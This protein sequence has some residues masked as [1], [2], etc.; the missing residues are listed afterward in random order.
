[1]CGRRQRGE[2]PGVRRDKQVRRKTGL[3][4]SRACPPVHIAK[5]R[6]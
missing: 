6:G 1:M 5:V 3:A 4:V 2:V